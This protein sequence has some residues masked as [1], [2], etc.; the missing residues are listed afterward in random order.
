MDQQNS[1]SSLKK[2]F[3]ETLIL[4]S[5][6]QEFKDASN[7]GNDFPDHIGVDEKVV[8][9]RKEPKYWEKNKEN[10]NIQYEEDHDPIQDAL[11]ESNSNFVI[12]NNRKMPDF[13]SG[14][15]KFA[16]YGARK[17]DVEDH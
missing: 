15:S 12:K 8:I 14:N 3:D 16:K 10:I 1:A 5:A 6:G 9:T 17:D 4:E 7:I 11:N 2:G 13:K